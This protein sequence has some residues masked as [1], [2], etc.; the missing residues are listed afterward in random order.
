VQQRCM[1]LRGQPDDWGAADPARPDAER[2]ASPSRR[3][4]GPLE[5]GRICDGDHLDRKILSGPDAGF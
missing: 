1:S 4:W 3:R 5:C 2:A